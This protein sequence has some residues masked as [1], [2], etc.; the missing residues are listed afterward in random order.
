MRL[1]RVPLL[2]LSW[3]MALAHPAAAQSGDTPPRRPPP[4]ESGDAWY[5]WQ[6]LAGDA[7]GVGGGLAALAISSSTSIDPAH[8]PNDA[9][10]VPTGVYAVGSVGAPALHWAHG[11]VGS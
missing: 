11:R 1:T 9:R 7:A 2:A 8:V 6:T 5:G 3:T 10:F 4:R